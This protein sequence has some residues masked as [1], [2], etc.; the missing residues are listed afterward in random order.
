MYTNSFLYR[1]FA[2]SAAFAVCGQSAVAQGF[3]KKDNALPD[4]SRF[5]MSR[6]QV[7]IIDE[8]PI[9]NRQ[10]NPP[11]AAGSNAIPGVPRRGLPRAGFQS[12][13]PDTP[14]LSTTL[15]KTNNGVPSKIVPGKAGSPTGNKGHAGKLGP[16]TAKVKAAPAGPSVEAYAPYKGWNP[17]AAP[18]TMQTSSTTQRNVRGVLHWARAQH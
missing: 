5:Y 15:P 11:G 16:A 4:S 18:A 7:Q 10:A 3:I 1:V 6:M 12:Y 8:T 17:G 9:I 14:S 13:S 2:L